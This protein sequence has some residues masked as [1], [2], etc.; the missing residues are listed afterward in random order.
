MPYDLNT[1]TGEYTMVRD[2][3]LDQPDHTY[4][5]TDPVTKQLLNM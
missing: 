4:K 3:K 1:D 5:I 2:G